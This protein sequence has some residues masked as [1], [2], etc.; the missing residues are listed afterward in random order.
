[1]EQECQG[2]IFE[3]ADHAGLKFC[4][5]R[6]GSREIHKYERRRDRGMSE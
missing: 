6:K 5:A 4:V 2:V 1:M 3:V